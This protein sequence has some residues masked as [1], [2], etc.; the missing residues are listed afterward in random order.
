ME[1]RQD[2][3]GITEDAISRVSKPTRYS[4]S[5]NQA[6]TVEIGTS[7]RQIVGRNMC[8]YPFFA[9]PL[10]AVKDVFMACAAGGAGE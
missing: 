3:H 1:K 9:L 7:A 4:S 10:G 6:E 8:V 5:I 2:I